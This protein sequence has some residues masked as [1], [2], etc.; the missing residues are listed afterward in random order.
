MAIPGAGVGGSPELVQPI[1]RVHEPPEADRIAGF[2]RLVAQVV[3]L[4]EQ[5][6]LAAAL[7]LDIRGTAFQQRVWQA[8]AAVLAH[9]TGPIDEE[10]E[11]EDDKIEEQARNGQRWNRGFRFWSHRHK[12]CPP[13]RPSQARCLRADAASRRPAKAASTSAA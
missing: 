2:E 1:Y 10:D 13:P 12:H 8:L 11:N 5:P 6:R 4:V 9:A 3:G 7:P